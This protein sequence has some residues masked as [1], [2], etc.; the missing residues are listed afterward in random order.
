MM[1]KVHSLA[2]A[3]SADPSHML[4]SIRPSLSE[5]KD[6]SRRYFYNLYR[7]SEDIDEDDV[8]DESGCE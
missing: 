3:H 1:T 2:K 8:E 4:L 7:L 6:G 5:L